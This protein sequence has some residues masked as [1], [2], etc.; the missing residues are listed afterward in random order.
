MTNYSVEEIKRICS[1]ANPGNRKLEAAKFYRD[2]LGWAIHPLCGPNANVKK[3]ERGKM[4]LCKGWRRWQKKDV[5]NEVLERHFGP[6]STANLGVVVRPPFVSVDLDSKE[7]HGQ[8]VR[9]WLA[10]RS[11]LKDV[12]RERSA[13]GVHLHFICRD[14]PAI[15]KKGKRHDKALVSHLTEKVTAELYFDGLNLVVSPSVHS[16][17][18]TYEWEVVGEIPEVTWAELKE[19]FQFKLPD[20]ENPASSDDKSKDEDW[21]RKYEGDLRTLNLAGL[22]KSLDMLGEVIKADEGK[23]AVKCPWHSEHS[24]NGRWD[25]KDSSTTIFTNSAESKWPGF[26]CLHSHCINRGLEDVL[27]YFEEQQPGCVDAYCKRQRIWKPGQSSEDGRPRLPLPRAGRPDSVFAAEAASLIGPKHCWFL[28]SDQVAQLHRHK[29]SEKLEYL[30]F[31]I[32]KPVE[33]CTAIEEHVEV[34]S[35]EWRKKELLFVPSSM[36]EQTAKLLIHAPQFKNKLPPVVRILD[37]PLP[38]RYEGEIV[39]ASK[40]YDS[41]FR[42]FCDTNAPDIT[43]MGI[44]EARSWLQKIMQ[45]FCWMA[46]QDLVH[47]IARLLTPFCRGLMGWDARFPLWFYE[48]NRPRAGKDYLFGIVPITYEGSPCEDPP[49]GDD[50]EVRKKITTAVRH[51]RRIMHF[52]NCRGYLDS[53]ALEQAVTSKNWTD[54]ILGGN[55]EIKVP[56]EIEFSLSANLGLTFTPDLGPRLRKIRLTYPQEDE[57]SRTFPIP[58]LHGWV[59]KHRSQILSAL[60]A[61]VD[62]WKGQGCPQG[63]TPFTSFPEWGRIVGGIMVSCGL[64]DPCLPHENGNEVGGDRLTLA[65]KDLFQL[66]HDA[67]KEAWL[68]KAQIYEV[69]QQ[70]Q[71]VVESL[72]FFGDLSDQSKEARSAKTR[73]GLNLRQFVDR[74]LGALQLQS[75][76][77]SNRTERAKY[78]LMP[79]RDVSDQG[80]AVVQEVLGRS[81]PVNPPPSNGDVGDVGD[82]SPLE[83]TEEDIS[84]IEKTAAEGHAQR[85]EGPKVTNVTKVTTPTLV[86]TVSGLEEIVDMV[87]RS[88]APIALDIETYGRDALNPRKGEI[89]LLSLGIPNHSPCLL[90]LKAIGYDLGPLKPVLEGAEVIGHNLKFDALWLRTK[91]GLVL[92]KPFCTMTASRL[93]TAGTKVANDLGECLRRYIQ[94][95]VP[96]DQAKSDWGQA[97]LSNKQISYAANDV[98]HLH[99]LKAAL[100]SEVEKNNLRRVLDLELELLPVVVDME[101]RGIQVNREGLLAIKKEAE[102]EAKSRKYD[103]RQLLADPEFNPSSPVQ[104]LEALRIRGNKIADTKEE[105]LVV[106]RD[107]LAKLVLEFRGAE[108]RATQA[109]T[110]LEAVA[111]DGRIHAAFNPLGTETGRFSSSK[112]NLQ[113]VGRGSLRQCFVAAPGNRLV[114]ADYSQIELR[115]AAA[116]SGEQRMLEAYNQGADLHKQTA[117]LVTQ[118]PMEQISKQDRQLAKAVNFGLLYGQSARGLV[119][120]ARKS[121]GVEL[122]EAEATKFHSLFFTNYRS[123]AVWHQEAWNQAWKKAVE[124]RTVLDRRRLLPTGATENWNRFTSLVN[125]PVQGSCAD[126]LKMAMVDLAKRLPEGAGIVSTVHDELIVEAPEHLV[127]KCKTLVTQS[128]EEA[129]KRLFPNLPVQVEVN[130]CANWGEK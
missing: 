86:T 82:V 2:Q 17:G 91:C 121:Y 110:L 73:L 106:C 76:T 102:D 77:R 98:L 93:L 51:G 70:N 130:D 26:S 92:K 27:G 78:R 23:T 13:G 57:N 69:V 124:V 56:N 63:L 81:N 109:T 112:P 125:A 114:V 34:G 71:E 68:E 61:L 18:P 54:R 53:K 105:T 32:L 10:S 74:V 37:V 1:P 50:E 11:E 64:G 90:D 89:R 128:M 52:A 25:P 47:A 87:K 111:A 65:M 66:C 99:Q 104:V 45:G 3:Q 127:E 96:K 39:Y 85:P 103:I 58:D 55:T 126:A 101:F 19:W 67:H 22:F 100:E 48:A 28:K 95:D 60:A 119:L 43:P 44:E 12:P 9:D 72:E 5:T 94:I 122:S 30:G 49:I 46:P 38:I 36:K 29:E 80:I 118:K 24:E 41:R 7:D 120:Y 14:L 20:E 6:G 59:F 88:A 97:L 16:S 113:N 4:P 8:S 117:S 21:W 116:I 75:E 115:V 108:K 42:S 83:I 107:E 31:A 84:K 79:V 123:L 15:K 33:V 129:M 62:Y 40:G 35:L